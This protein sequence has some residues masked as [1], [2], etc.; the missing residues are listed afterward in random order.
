M[1]INKRHALL[2]ALAAS[3]ALNLFFV[4]AIG[5]RMLERR[6]RPSTPPTLVWILRDLEPRVQEALRPQLQQY[7]ESLRPVRGQM[8][9]A[10]REVNRL[11]VQDPLDEEAVLAAFEE[12][13]Q[14]SV[15]YQQMSHEQTLAV[16]SQL[17][18]EL[19]SR[20]FRFM[21][22][23]RNPVEGGGFRHSESDRSNRVSESE[24]NGDI[25]P[26]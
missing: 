22:G 11:L 21:S 24:P 13:R 6:D 15:R 23:R 12:L 10:Q 20:V 1:A 9:R 17:A 16:V 26:D 3:L 8:F 14:I 4:G 25:S 19:R 2:W 7:G 5:A 18:P